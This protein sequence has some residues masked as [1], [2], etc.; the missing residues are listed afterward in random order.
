MP[1]THIAWQQYKVSHLRYTQKATVYNRI[2]LQSREGAA[3]LLSVA[4]T[5]GLLLSLLL[6]S[7]RFPRELSVHSCCWSL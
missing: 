4:T 6:P 3:L 5:A 2:L 1:L 7:I